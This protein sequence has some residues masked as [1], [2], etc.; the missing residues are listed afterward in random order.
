MAHIKQERDSKTSIEE[1]GHSKKLAPIVT[2]CKIYLKQ[3]VVDWPKE[4]LALVFD[5]DDTVL[6]QTSTGFAIPQAMV[7]LYQ[8]AREHGFKVCFVTAR[9]YSA[10]A[11][12]QTQQQLASAGFS[13]YD[14]LILM[15]PECLQTHPNWSLYKSKA[16]NMI[17]R[18]YHIVLN[19][20]D[21]WGD[22]MLLEPFEGVHPQTKTLLSK[23]G[24]NSYVIFKAPDVSWVSVKLPVNKAN[25]S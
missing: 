17:A 22:L 21:N 3:T 1:L 13:E 15:P 4:A 14:E 16:R 7:E 6:F 24:E 11:V 12:R 10:D 18:K 2:W 20:G 8:F 5:I 25:K 23:H 19:M 9:V